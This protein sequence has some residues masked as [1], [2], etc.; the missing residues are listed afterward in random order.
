MI[1]DDIKGFIQKNGILGLG[2]AVLLGAMIAQILL[3]IVLSV[4]GK[5][6]YYGTVM[7]YVMIIGNKT[8][9]RPW[10]LFSY[11]FI[12][13]LNLQGLI[14][15][16]VDCMFFW[17]F[18]GMFLQLWGSE[19]LK[20]FLIISIPLLGFVG[21]IFS[22]I[23][24][25]QAVY[26]AAPIIMAVVFSISFLTPD[27]PVSLWGVVQMKMVFFAFV[28]LLIEFIAWGVSATGFTILLGAFWGYFFTLQMKKGNDYSL[29]V[30]DY[31]QSLFQS[32]IKKPNFTVTVNQSPKTDD[33]GVSQAEIDAIL[34]KISA[35]GYQS[36]TREEK[37]KLEKFSGKRKSDN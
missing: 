17:S 24:G 28:A 2:I 27:Y 8:L 23:Y 32:K 4:T 12:Y 25:N 18:G 33:S 26:T 9:F 30:F 36:L 22:V 3:S 14:N 35:T 37:E 10:T 20:R 34:D 6:L 1:I 16:L 15:F 11:A 21:A 7:R 31:V 29:I 5:E 13:N 19:R